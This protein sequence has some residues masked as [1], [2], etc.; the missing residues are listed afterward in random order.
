M[1]PIFNTEV[2]VRWHDLDA[3]GHVNHVHYF[4]YFEQA[5]IQWWRSLGLDFDKTGPVL[6]TAEANYLKP[7]FFPET[8]TV[9]LACSPPGKTSYTIFYEVLSKN[10]PEILYAR[11]STKVV[12]VDYQLMKPVLLPDLMLKHL[13]EA[14]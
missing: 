11:G 1:N 13:S 10:H 6:I 5:R 9:H 14:A 7:V 4:T 12:W 3:L 2:E 8:L